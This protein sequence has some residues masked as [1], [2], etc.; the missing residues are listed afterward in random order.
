MVIH[1]RERVGTQGFV[2]TGIGAGVASNVETG[3]DIGV[4][5]R[6]QTFRH[7]NNSSTRS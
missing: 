6:V 4:G 2:G 1:V 3:A 5:S 7:E